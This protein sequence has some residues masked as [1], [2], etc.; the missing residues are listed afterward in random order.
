MLISNL[1]IIIKEKSKKSNKIFLSGYETYKLILIYVKSNVQ[2][3][4]L[5]KAFRK[6]G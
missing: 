1:I 4:L 3:G 5:Y 6:V 2:A